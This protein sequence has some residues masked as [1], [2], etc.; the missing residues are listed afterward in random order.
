MN[1]KE[2][3]EELQKRYPVEDKTHAEFKVSAKWVMLQ[4]IGIA[5][6]T[7]VTLVTV[8]FIDTYI[9]PDVNAKIYIPS[10]SNNYWS[11]LMVMF[12]IRFIALLLVML[13]HFPIAFKLYHGLWPLYYFYWINFVVGPAVLGP[14]YSALYIAAS[15]VT[16]F[17]FTARM[18]AVTYVVTGKTLTIRDGWV[19][20]E[21]QTRVYSKLDKVSMKQSFMGRLFG[22]GTITLPGT[23]IPEPTNSLF[24]VDRPEEVW[25][26]I[27]HLMVYRDFSETME[28]VGSR[29]EEKLNSIEKK[30]DGPTMYA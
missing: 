3:M 8:M 18:R 21:M 4:L 27:S 28:R 29:L 5:F 9:P 20:R 1:E 25:K 17:L 7:I 23:L 30:L 24:Q 12:L 6:F 14:T 2:L 22:Y 16:A 11:R 13:V 26:A 15:A 10:G 19:V